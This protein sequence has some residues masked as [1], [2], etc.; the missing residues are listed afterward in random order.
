MMGMF[1]LPDSPRWLANKNRKEEAQACLRL[2]YKP[3]FVQVY[4][5]SLEKE[6]KF[7]RNQTLLRWFPKVKELFRNYKK[8][9]GMGCGLMVC[10][11]LSGITIVNS[12]GPA[13]VSNARFNQHGSCYNDLTQSSIRYALL[14]SL[15]LGFVRV[16]GTIIAIMVVDRRGRRRV[17]LRTIPIIIVCVVGLTT[18]FW[19]FILEIGC[20]VAKFVGLICTVMFLVTYS[21]GLDTIPWLVNS[22]IYPP[23]LIGT[24]SSLAAFT[25]WFINYI[26]LQTFYRDS[27]DL[28]FLSLSVANVLSYMFVW[29]ACTETNGNTN[30]KNMSLI[31]GKSVREVTQMMK[32]LGAQPTQLNMDP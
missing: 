16:L 21:A 20:D 27:P 5:N 4:I 17:L 11:Q 32:G 13:L 14:W 19:L 9:L 6:N 24:A 25:N 8:C 15:P 28:Y 26:L 2:V 23:A 31:L 12:Y 1:L 7:G 22:E 18:A 10:Q 3:A 30:I 29:Y